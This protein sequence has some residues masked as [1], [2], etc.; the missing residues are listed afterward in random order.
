[1]EYTL[2]SLPRKA[3]QP[4][5]RREPRYKLTSALQFKF[6]I[7]EAYLFIYQWACW[8]WA[9][10]SRVST[11]L[12]SSLGSRLRIK[13]LYLEIYL[14]MGNFY[15]V[16]FARWEHQWRSHEGTFH[17]REG[18]W[19]K[20]HPSIIVVLISNQ[21]GT[22]LWLLTSQLILWEVEMSAVGQLAQTR[23]D[24]IYAQRETMK[25]SIAP[26]VGS[27]KFTWLQ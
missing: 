20:Y 6:R 7:F 12:P 24:H 16:D 1:M 15:S 19:W 9:E 27:L 25:S 22:V 5:S 4:S 17:S 2:M 3:M 10:E 23:R 14:E 26:K 13:Q 11:C 8:N 18:E 21:D